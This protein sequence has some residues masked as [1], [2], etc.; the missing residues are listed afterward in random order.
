MVLL[1]L[2]KRVQQMRVCTEQIVLLRGSGPFG[3]CSISQSQ[4]DFVLTLYK[5]KLTLLTL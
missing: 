3:A 5:V 1:V 2:V 4:L